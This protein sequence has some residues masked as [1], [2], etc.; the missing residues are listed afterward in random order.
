MQFKNKNDSVQFSTRYQQYIFV[1]RHFRGTRR[2]QVFPIGETNKIYN[3]KSKQD[4]ISN[5]I[6]SNYQKGWLNKG[7]RTF[8]KIDKK[9]NKKKNQNYAATLTGGGHSGGNHSDMDLLK[10]GVKIRRLTP[11]ECERLQGFPDG[12]TAKGTINVPFHKVGRGIIQNFKFVEISDA[13]RYKTLGNAVTVNVI[14][15]IM[16]KLLST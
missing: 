1:K 12:W 3:K 13:Q 5:C 2:P 7:Q 16:K 14:K 15:E 10:Q 11:T 4:K 9:G 6:D 8:I